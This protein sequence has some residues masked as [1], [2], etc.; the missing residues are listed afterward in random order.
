MH[1]LPY[2][3]LSTYYFFYFA[4]IGA[5]SP[6]FG[7]YLQTQGL[8]AWE[9]GLLM[10]QMQLMRLLG[11]NVWGWLADR[12]QRRV[13]IVQLA[14]LVSLLG[15]SAFFWVRHL[16]GMLAAMAVLAFFWSAALPLIETLTFDHLRES[17][18][19]YS[20]IRVWGSIGFIVAVLAT[21]ALLDH[22]PMDAVLW[23]CWLLLAGILGCALLLP[24]AAPPA[25][26]PGRD[27]L[28]TIL[29]QP[30]V[31]ALLLGG[32]TMAA[33]HGPFYVFYSIHLAHHGYN[34]TEIGLLWSLGV[35]AEIFVFMGMA[36]LVTRYSLRTLLLVS[37]AAAVLRFLM[38]AW[39]VDVLILAVIAQILHGLTFGA[40]HAASLAAVNHCFPGR[41]Q[42]RGQALYSSLGFGAGG[43]A[44]SLLS[45][46]IWEN[47]GAGWIY[48]LASAFALLGW[49][50]VFAG[51]KGAG[52]SSI[53]AR[54]VR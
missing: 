17:R 12:R 39:W 23:V 26:H 13:P 35:V 28:V 34:T 25:A 10:S 21:G 53:P 42:S 11:P 51:L 5:F 31:L 3:R 6:Y 27:S 9:I 40:H 47:L 37:F 43:L 41:A 44:G 20:R 32:F 14:A 33:A 46:S 2:W 4:F 7:L 52:L 18:E 48:A 15:F 36:R 19:R 22:L 30:A 38:I 1:A 16:S 50:T 24:E 49:L 29:R 54:P 45:A 8:T